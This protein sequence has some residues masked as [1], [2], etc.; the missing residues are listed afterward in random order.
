MIHSAAHTV[1]YASCLLWVVS[2]FW[3]ALREHTVGPDYNISHTLPDC[4]V[5]ICVRVWDALIPSGR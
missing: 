4:A 2:K 1:R 3:Q 5:H